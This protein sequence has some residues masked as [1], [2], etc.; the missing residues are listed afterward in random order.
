MKKYMIL[1]K[2]DYNEEIFYTDIKAEAKRAFDRMMDKYIFVKAFCYNRKNELYQDI[3]EM[4]EQTVYAVKTY[5][6]A[7][8]NQT[9][10]GVVEELLNQEYYEFTC[11]EDALVY[12]IKS[13]KADRKFRLYKNGRRDYSV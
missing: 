4:N 3:T 2:N 7:K 6:G 8:L 10:D 1:A 11:K 12:I 9:P 5:S 13:I